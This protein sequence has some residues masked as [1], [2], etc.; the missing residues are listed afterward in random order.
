MHKR[1]GR[2]LD[3][4]FTPPK[5]AH[6]TFDQL[7]LSDGSVVPVHSD[8]TV[9]I[10]RVANSRYLPRHSVLESGKNSRARWPH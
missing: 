5:I 1:V 4:D 9:G 7:V 6:V 10:G 8:S 2:L 3:G